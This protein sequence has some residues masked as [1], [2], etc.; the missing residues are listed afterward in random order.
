[1]AAL[2]TALK[3]IE[4]VLERLGLS[5]RPARPARPARPVPALDRSPSLSNIMHDLDKNLERDY[6][7]AVRTERSVPEPKRTPATTQPAGSR[8]SLRV[9]DVLIGAVRD[10][11]ERL[12]RARSDFERMD[13]NDGL[14]R[15]VRQTVDPELLETV[16]G[17]RLASKWV[18]PLR[19]QYARFRQARPAEWEAVEKTWREQ[20]NLWR[21]RPQTTSPL[22][23]FVAGHV[24]PTPPKAPAPAAGAAERTQ[25]QRSSH[26]R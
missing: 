1:M 12:A 11:G 9:V 8:K 2:D 19:A 3:A 10:S 26:D 20:R 7:A 18:D 14:K 4:R 16:V 23:T 15:L 17:P 6:P 5:R 21:P 22:P 25:Q 24:N 13:P